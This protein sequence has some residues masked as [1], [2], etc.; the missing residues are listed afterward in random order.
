MSETKTLRTVVLDVG[1]RKKREIEQLKDGV[2]PLADQARDAAE[3]AAPATAAVVPVVIVYEKRPK[4]QPGLL[5]RLLRK[6]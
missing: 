4:K 1:A 5:G 3:R 6:R 2:G